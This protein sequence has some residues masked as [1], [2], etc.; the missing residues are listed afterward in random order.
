MV[1]SLAARRFSAAALIALAF[2]I[3]A[4]AQILSVIAPEWLNHASRLRHYCCS[5]SF[6]SITRAGRDLDAVDS[7]FSRAL[8]IADGNVADALLATAIA[9]I[10]HP[11]I[12]VKLGIVTLPIPLV[13]ED[14]DLYRCAHNHLPTRLF[15]DSPKEGDGDKLQHF[16]GSAYLQWVS[17]SRMIAGFIGGAIET[18]EPTLVVGGAD[19][20]RDLRADK[21]GQTFALLIK[22]HTYVPPSAVLK[23]VR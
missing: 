8:C 16:F 7:L 21:A 14:M 6:A 18:L 3:P 11:V 20:P 5:E 9:C 1:D 10:D 13:I 4:S 2:S 19:D 23:M 12:H 22:N 15:F 17:D